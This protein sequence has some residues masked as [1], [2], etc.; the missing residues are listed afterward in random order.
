MG[1]AFQTPLTE[2]I[3]QN[4]LNAIQKR[5]LSPEDRASA[6]VWACV[7][8]K[9]EILRHVYSGNSNMEQLFQKA[10]ERGHLHILR[11][12]HEEK[13]AD[14][15]QRDYL[16]NACVHGHENIVKYLM[17][18]GAPVSNDALQWTFCNG[19]VGLLHYF[20]AQGVNLSPLNNLVRGWA[21]PSKFATMEDFLEQIGILPHVDTPAEKQANRFAQ[22]EARITELETRLNAMQN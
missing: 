18:K 15:R 9:L 14:L 17:S 6:T 12:L 8:G 5:R 1:N 21:R 16:A 10:V 13:G 7:Y 19:R 4:D 3:Q 22:M 11:Y 2:L 20:H